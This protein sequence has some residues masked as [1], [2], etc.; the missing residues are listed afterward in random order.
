MKHWHSSFIKSLSHLMHSWIYLYGETCGNNIRLTDNAIARILLSYNSCLC[1]HPCRGHRSICFN[2]MKSLSDW[3]ISD[4]SCKKR[5]TTLCVI[6]GALYSTSAVEIYC[7]GQQVH[8]SIFAITLSNFFSFR[9]L[10][11]VHFKNKFPV[12]LCIKW[13]TENQ[14]KICLVYLLTCKNA[15]Y[16]SLICCGFK[17]RR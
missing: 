5:C 3:S 2:F 1:A 12:V 16:R 13:K 15:L 11:H 7:V 4:I 8:R 17:S 10:W 9:K 6:V 14:L